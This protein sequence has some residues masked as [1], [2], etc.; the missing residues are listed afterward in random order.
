VADLPHTLAQ[1]RAQLGWL[2]EK[3]SSGSDFVLGN[4]AGLTDLLA[5]FI[6]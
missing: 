3:L 6:V 1:L 5:W 2:E 4:Q